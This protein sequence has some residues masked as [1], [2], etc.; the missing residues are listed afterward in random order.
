MDPVHGGINFFSHEK[1]IIDHKNFQRLRH[2][3][4]NDV[5]FLVFPGATH[6]RLEHSIG[7]MDVAGRIFQ[8]MLRNYFSEKHIIEEFVFE[9]DTIGAIQYCYACLRAA[10]LLHDTGHFPFSHQFESSEAGSLLLSNMDVVQ[11]V[12][13]L[14][15][16]L[17]DKGTDHLAHEHLSIISAYKIIT[18]IEGFPLEVHDVISIM[19]HGV[20]KPSAKFTTCAKKILEIFMKKELLA[21]FTGETISQKVIELL[22]NIISGEIDADKMDYLLRDSYYTGCNYGMYNI[23]HLVRNIYV[24]YDAIT[25]STD[26]WV[27]IALNK[28]GLGALEDFVYSRFRMYLQVYSHKTAIGLK[29]LLKKAIS[30]AL[31]NADTKNFLTS[32]IKDSDFFC[33]L[34]DTFFWETFRKCSMKTPNS[35]SSNLLNRKVLTSIKSIRAYD[36]HVKERIKRELAANPEYR[37]VIYYESATKFSKIKPSYDKIRLLSISK[38][39]RKRQ[40]ESITENSDFFDKFND[41]MEV[42]YYDAPDF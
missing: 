22:K 41:I 35:A 37:N 27:G 18:E 25:D 12:S 38:S 14:S 11:Y 9:K 31:S 7:T 10:A 20:V 1:K 3:K 23:D 42:H 15:G 6:T 28:K 16:G 24:G 2:I 29:W 21:R 34:T 26:P 19:E 5:L 33:H 13:Q 40:L 30:D 8:A 17:F 32:C 39:I 4:Q 36:N